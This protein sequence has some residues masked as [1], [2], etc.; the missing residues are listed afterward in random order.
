[1]AQCFKIH[2]MN[3]QT[4]LI[5]QTVAIIRSGG[6]IV[7]PTDS[8]YALGCGIGQHDALERICRIRKLDEKHHFTLVCRDLKDVSSYARF[9]TPIYRLLKAHTPGSYT[10]ILRATKEVP[11]RLM[12]PKQKTIGLRIPDHPI[13]QT[14]LAE[15]GDPMLTTTL[16]FPG[17]SEPM[18]QADEIQK[19]LATQV[20][21]VIDGGPGGSMPT[22]LVDLVEDVP[23]ILRIGKGDPKPFQ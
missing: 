4:R 19:R 23:R 20:D 6:L 16:I 13:V 18:T 7:Y 11:R 1:M 2:P 10:F 22:T 5:R 14:L 15:L 3:P 9:D 8:G 21:L 12:H 17:E